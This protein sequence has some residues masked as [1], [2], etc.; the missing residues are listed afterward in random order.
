[1]EK[2]H[3]TAKDAAKYLGV[4]HRH[5]L[6]LIRDGK[7]KAELQNTPVPYFLIDMESLEDYAKNG[8]R[9]PGPPKG[10]GGRPK[11]EMRN[12]K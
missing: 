5:V 1:M 11:K 8:K 2:K 6:S 4:R 12:K 7:L 9:K 3:L 10:Q